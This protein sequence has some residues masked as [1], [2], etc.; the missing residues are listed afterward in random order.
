[1][2]ATKTR[3]R[4]EQKREARVNAKDPFI[5]TLAAY[6]ELLELPGLHPRLRELY[7]RLKLHAGKDGRC[8]PT[9]TRRSRANSASE[10]PSAGDKF[11]GQ[12]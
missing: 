11:A 7:G 12:T 2:F 3:R 6:D 1:M 10:N 9:S 5:Q 4:Q 8:Y